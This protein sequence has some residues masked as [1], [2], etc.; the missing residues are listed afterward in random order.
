MLLALVCAPA[1]AEPARLDPQR[2]DEA[3]RAA[4]DDELQAELPRYAGDGSGSARHWDPNRRGDQPFDLPE[5]RRPVEDEA[6]PIGPL[7]T[8]LNLLMWG[9]LVV[10]SI[11][12][13]FWLSSELVRYGGEDA[14]LGAEDPDGAAPIDLAV[15]ERPLG[16][17]EELAAR[18]DYADA[19]HTLLLR[20]LVEL[21]RSSAVRVGPAL[22]SREILARVP[23]QA[24]ARE[25]LA[26]LIT[27]VEVTHFG[28]DI[29]TV[30]DYHRCREQFQRF[31]S[32]FRG[33]AQPTRR[34]ADG[35]AKGRA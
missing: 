10:G 34:T 4:L 28:D 31:A 12:V 20:T 15:I 19:I 8:L 11:L 18:G 16:D 26:G 24:D 2:I 23:L 35:R 13:A 5:H 7:G 21:V 29:A 27:A 6:G 9:L 30:A 17:A 25:A 32:A 22:T 3:A 14:E 1:G 33:D